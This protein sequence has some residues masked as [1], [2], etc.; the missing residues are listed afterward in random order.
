V[1][2]RTAR[3]AQRNPVSKKKNQKKKKRIIHIQKISIILYCRVFYLTQKVLDL[4][5][6]SGKVQ[7]V[8]TAYKKTIASIYVKK[9]LA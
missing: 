4:I 5:N 2:S 3:A 9:T 1:S 7:D 8:K 6:S